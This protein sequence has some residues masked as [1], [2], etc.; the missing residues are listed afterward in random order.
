MN[1]D[2]IREY[3]SYLSVEKGLA[4]NSLEAY[5]R[6]LEKLIG[7][8]EAKDDQRRE[9]SASAFMKRLEADRKKVGMKPAE[10]FKIAEDQGPLGLRAEI[11][12]RLKKASTMI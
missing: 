7:A 8:L 6:D 11:D 12:R 5:E 4:K 3:L 10:F 9:R 2:L 1:R